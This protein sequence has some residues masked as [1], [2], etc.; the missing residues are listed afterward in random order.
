M[1]ANVLLVGALVVWSATAAGAFAGGR[2]PKNARQYE[3][4]GKLTDAGPDGEKAVTVL[5]ALS[6]AEGEPLRYQA[7]GAN[8]FSGSVLSGPNAGPPYG[9]DLGIT[10]RRLKNGKVRLALAVKNS[11]TE[12]DPNV[13]R[14]HS[15]SLEAVRHVRLGK[16]LTVPLECD[17]KGEAKVWLELTVNE[18]QD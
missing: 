14:S 11:H 8:A 7:G 3:V 4:R 2:A 12:T 18:A 16:S 15:V 1:R 13:S 6:T 17:A 9:L 10:V 5:P